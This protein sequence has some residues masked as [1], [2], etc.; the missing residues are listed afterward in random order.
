MIRSW[1]LRAPSGARIAPVET[2]ANDPPA[3][4]IASESAVESCG[5]LASSEAYQATR[6]RA[7]PALGPGQSRPAAWY[8]RP[9]STVKDW[10][11]QATAVPFEVSDAAREPPSE[12]TRAFPAWARQ[13]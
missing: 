7:R 11:S 13:P 5:P 3:P 8:Q 6:M 9:P 4:S 12:V 1:A 2:V 10:C